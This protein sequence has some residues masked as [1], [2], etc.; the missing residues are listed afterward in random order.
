MN[1]GRVGYAPSLAGKLRELDSILYISQYRK[2]RQ[3]LESSLHAA[4]GNR[5][6]KESRVQSV[7]PVEIYS[8]VWFSPSDSAT[9]VHLFRWSY[10]INPLFSHNRVRL[11]SLQTS[12]K[13]NGNHCWMTP[14]LS[15]P[16]FN[17][18]NG[19]H[20]LSESDCISLTLLNISFFVLKWYIFAE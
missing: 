6:N 10:C 12:V 20:R 5:T 9:R 13:R 19:L 8:R 7:G 3:R 11:L 16:I 1:R 15:S 14:Y 18:K 2:M 4:S 17:W